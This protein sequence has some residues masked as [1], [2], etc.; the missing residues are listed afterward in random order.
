M[1]DWPN[2]NFNEGKEYRYSLWNYWRCTVVV[3]YVDRVLSH[4]FS[5]TFSSWSERRFTFFFAGQWD[6]RAGYTMRKTFAKIFN[7]NAGI[8]QRYTGMYKMCVQLKF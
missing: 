3:P 4:E 6:G 2:I 5:P 1:E 8:S 7:A